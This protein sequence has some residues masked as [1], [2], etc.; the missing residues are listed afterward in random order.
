M[1]PPDEDLHVVGLTAETTQL[2]ALLDQAR[3]GG[4]A[5]ALVEG[6]AGI[7][8]TT[9]LRR[10]LRRHPE[11][12]TT[13]AAGLPWE[14]RRA[15]A[16]ARRLLDDVPHD[17]SPEPA[18]DDPVDLGVALARHWAARAGEQPLLVVVDDADCA[19]PV[20]LQAIGSA[21]ARVRRNPVVLLLTRTTGW[22]ETGDPGAGAVLDRLAAVSVPV[23]PLGP[24][25]IR[26]LAARVA[27]VDLPGPVARRLSE[28]TAGIPRQ[29]LELIRDTP[30]SRWSDRHLRMPAP[31]GIQRRVQ[32]ALD[33]C[34]PEARALVQAA[35]VLGQDPVLAD[36][37]AVAGLTD[38]IAALEEACAADL[39]V[40]AAGHGL[41]ALAFPAR[42]VRTAV[43][44]TLSPQARHDLHLRAAAVVTDDTERL[45]HRVEAAPLPDADL[46]DELVE[47]A[48]RKADEGA[49]AVVARTLV[50]ASR[51]SPTRVVRE[52]RLIEA[53][54][55]LAGAGLIGQ[56]VDAL[57]EVEAL[58]AGPHRDAVLAHVAIQRGR[59][60]EAAIHLD[61][62][63]RRRGPDRRAAAVVCQRHVLHAL[64]DWDGEALVQWAGRAVEHA[65]PGTPAAVESRAIVGLGHAARGDVAAAFT[66]YR[67]AVAESPTGP[68][69][70]R[71]R[72]GLGW[73]SLA[74]D[75][76]EAARRELEFAVPT[77]RQAGSNR[78]SLWALVWLART[79][80]ALG[81]WPGALDAVAEGEA[82]LGT[83]GL[84]L[85]R[86][87]VHWTGAQIRALCGEPEA[88]ERHLR[89]G[90]AGEQDYTV[91]TVPALL[92]R[93]HAA[94]AASD[95]PAVVR[96]LAPLT[97]RMPRGGLDEPGFWPWH[98]VYAEA[99]VATDRLLEAEEFLAPVEA[100]A[101]LR[102]HRSA[103][104]RLGYVRGRLLAA[105]GD[106]AGAEAVFEEARSRLAELPLPY[107]RARGDFVH[108]LTLR[109]AGRR[110]DAAALLT[111]ARQVFAALG[112]QVYV[113]RCDRELKTGRPALRGTDA[114]A[115]GLTE[116]ERS[117]AELV[118]TGLTNK[119]VAASMLLSVKTVQFHLT[120]VYTKLGVRSRSELAARFSREAALRGDGGRGRGAGAVPGGDDRGARPAARR[121]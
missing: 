89:L 60:T 92:A 75:D 9:L 77:A 96:H 6:P 73:L 85:L 104:A 46:A 66:A 116:Q 2:E 78:I 71:A 47:L 49:W 117:V 62:A 97:T 90:G 95:H 42:L 17:A 48:R 54:D 10:F 22:P 65:E 38:P 108:G 59:R 26:L 55:A 64:A 114:G 52:D 102:G 45:R 31:A 87:L 20:S 5:V 119:E 24:A 106:I 13:T 37:A 25:E 79:R 115:H 50:D 69:H 88:A 30:R 41:D 103:S 3:A 39:L 63:W 80:V 29:V 57:P 12:P 72:M 19:D 68:Q 23:P 76:P 83:T 58:P 35:A 28:H 27:E 32:R 100:V 118:A 93:A 112:A 81:D 107:D 110:R 44:G 56:A 94:E 53:V 120:R 111:T 113:E 40:I 67:H 86:P 1:S 70:Q 82:L 33:L 121:G 18:G 16:L 8:K 74:Q 7:G 105:R 34:S 4:P 84:D 43:Q 14:N 91:M 51:I 21:V 61:A 15:G 99:L 109:R 98:E 36:A 11:L 101:Q